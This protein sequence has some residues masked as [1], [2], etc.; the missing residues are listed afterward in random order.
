M[1]D[2]EIQLEKIKQQNNLARALGL[3]EGS[4]EGLDFV[5][6]R[7]EGLVKNLKEIKQILEEIVND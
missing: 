7:K 3:V 5:E 1:W 4:I 6:F 2:D